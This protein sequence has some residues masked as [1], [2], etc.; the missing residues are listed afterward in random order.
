MVVVVLNQHSIEK[1]PAYDMAPDTVVNVSVLP[2]KLV[3]QYPLGQYGV[4]EP[5][6]G[7]PLRVIVKLLVL[8]SKNVLFC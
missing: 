1:S 7:V 8:E 6:V 3:L 5:C 4:T 2:F